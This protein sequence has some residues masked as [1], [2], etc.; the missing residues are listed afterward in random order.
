L[1]NDCGW[2]TYNIGTF[3]QDGIHPNALGAARMA[4]VIIKKIQGLLP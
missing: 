1:N 4:N 3:L 2:N